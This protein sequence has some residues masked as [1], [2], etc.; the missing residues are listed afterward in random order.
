MKAH[1]RGGDIK[2]QLRDAQKD[3]DDWYT[4]K[5]PDDLFQFNIDF[6]FA[7]FNENY[8]Q[9]EV[10]DILQ[11]TSTFNQFQELVNSADDNT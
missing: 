9:F 10:H 1:T 11:P 7:L 3:E 2:V 5:S 8:F 4:I 6:D